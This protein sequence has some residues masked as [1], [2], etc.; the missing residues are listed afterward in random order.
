MTA[1]ASSWMK[2]P[3]LY[4]HSWSWTID[5]FLKSLE[6]KWGS[7]DCSLHWVLLS[8]NRCVLFAEVGFIYIC[9]I[10]LLPVGVSSWGSRF[11]Y[12]NGL[13][14]PRITPYCTVCRMQLCNECRSS[15]THTPA[16]LGIPLLC[17]VIILYAV[18]LW[19]V[20]KP[21]AVPVQLHGSHLHLII[22]GQF[23]PCS[24]RLAAAI[25][26]NPISTSMVIPW[27][28]YNMLLWSD[29][30]MV[31]RYVAESIAA[32][33]GRFGRVG[34]C[35]VHATFTCSWRQSCNTIGQCL[36]NIACLTLQYL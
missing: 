9:S 15:G 21:E 1:R 33:A 6:G 2:Y 20:P 7:K 8:A 36:L 28:M 32:D 17:N 5:I 13:G 29:E 14:S 18:A 23:A 19:R 24:S 34:L 30:L 22:C 3:L 27:N 10:P 26:M 31:S 4:L 11:P 35:Q 16:Q 12:R 25:W